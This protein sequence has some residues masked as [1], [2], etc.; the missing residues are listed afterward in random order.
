[1]IEATCH[2]GAVHIEVPEAPTQLTSCNCSICRRLGM[3]MAYYHPEQVNVVGTTVT[4]AWGDKSLA[5]HRCTI[6]GCTTH[7]KSIDPAQTERMGVNARLMD[8][9]VLEGVRVRKFDG[10]ATWEFLD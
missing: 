6:C 1:M 3:L 2:C 10:A 8:P 4:Y 7:W 9:A 5:F